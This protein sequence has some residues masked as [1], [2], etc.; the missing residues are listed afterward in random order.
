MSCTPSVTVFCR[1]FRVTSLAQAHKVIIIVCSA[2]GQRNYVVNLLGGCKLTFL[3]AHLTKRMICN[4]SVTDSFSRSSVPFLHLRRTVILLVALVFLLLMFLAEPSVR[5]IWTAGM[6]TRAFRFLWHLSSPRF[7]HKKSPHRISPV[8]AVCI[9]FFH[10][11]IIP[12]CNMYS[13]GF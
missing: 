6:G 9:H 12:Y 13:S 8:K 1:Y 5:K 3:Q 4:M 2:A 11:T 7:G 10:I